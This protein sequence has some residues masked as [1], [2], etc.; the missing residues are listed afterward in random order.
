MSLFGDDPP[1]AQRPKSSLFDD[2]PGTPTKSS[3][4]PS[5]H[6]RG[7]SSSIFADDP[8]S[9]SSAQPEDDSPWGFTPKK[10]T[11]RRGGNLVKALLADASV[12]E[13]YVDAFDDLQSAGTVNADDAQQLVKDCGVGV[14]DRTEIWRIVTAGERETEILGRNEFFVLLALIGLA[15]EGEELGLDAVDE[16]RGRLPAVRMPAGK[17]AAAAA[18]PPAQSEARVGAQSGAQAQSSPRKASFG[19]GFGESDPWGSPEMHKDHNHSNGIGATQRT[20]STFTT[21]SVV[22]STGTTSGSYGNGEVPSSGGGSWGASAAYSASGAAGFGNGD[23]ADGGFGGE[24]TGP[25]APQRR[26]QQPKVST[27]KGVEEVITVGLLDEKEGMFMFQH[28]NYEVASTRRNSKVIR[29]YSDFVWLLDC[30]HKRYPFRQLPLLPPKRVSIN[31]NHIASDSAFLEK[32]RRGLV[33]FANALVRHPV[34]REEQLVVMFLTVPTVDACLLFRLYTI[35]KIAFTGTRRLEKA[36]HH[37]CPR[38]I[39]WA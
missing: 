17:K 11:N 7:G 10:A 3:N 28:R 38:R 25:S 12:P 5:K 1:S 33:R 37:Q 16:R 31:G 27:G 8:P 14:G 13:A 6:A 19:A 9:T 34:L 15:Q 30:L 35:A 36:S 39:R 32:R 21:A 18:A 29:R 24:G 2:G 20:T 22:D 23:A 26:P 4:S